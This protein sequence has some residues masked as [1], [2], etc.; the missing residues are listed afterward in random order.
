MLSDLV[1]EPPIVATS[2]DRL[3][4]IMLDEGVKGAYSARG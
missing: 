3:S 1:Q 4:S 2:K